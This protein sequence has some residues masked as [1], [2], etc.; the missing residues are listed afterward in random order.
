MYWLRVLLCTLLVECCNKG[1]LDLC[2]RLRQLHMY[3]QSI[4]PAVV[5]YFVQYNT[6]QV[7]RAQFSS[8]ASWGRLAEATC[9]RAQKPY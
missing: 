3:N 8:I 1:T 9:C 6:V 2:T 4:N 5:Q 7:S